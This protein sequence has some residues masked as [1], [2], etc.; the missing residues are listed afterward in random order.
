MVPL[1]VRTAGGVSVTGLALVW[2]MV[3]MVVWRQ[4]ILELA[5]GYA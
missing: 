3:V 2:A 5:V 4:S 1:G